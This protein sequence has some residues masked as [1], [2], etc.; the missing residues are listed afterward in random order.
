MR[1]MSYRSYGRPLEAVD[2]EIPKPGRGQ[3]LVKG[4]TSSVNPVDWKQA[5]GKI[6][7]IMPNKL[8]CVPGY[9][10]AG[11]VVTY[12]ADVTGFAPGDRVHARIAGINGG[13]CAEYALCGIDVLA[14]MPDGMD[15]ATAAGLPL[16]GMTA[17][18]GLRD[19]AK[20]PMHGATER[21]L[22]VGASGGV[23]H[24]ALQIARAAGATVFAVSSDRNA[25]LVRELGAS[26]VLDYNKPATF[27]DQPPFDVIFD[28]VAGDASK[29]CGLLTK[30]GRYA[31][32]VPGA[33]TFVRTAMSLFSSQRVAP[34]MLKS[35]AADLAFLDALFQAN[36]LRILIG[37]RFPLASLQDAWSRSE[38]GRATGKLIVDIAN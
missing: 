26:D 12:G 23:G 29:W 31:S 24:I 21:V 1:A 16:A 36:K 25:G 19:G 20:L 15:F 17:L 11:E 32:C 8:P 9:D 3:V 27:G 13:A 7:L 4:S 37:A 38:S 2:L 35:N 22:V 14:K 10:Y 18:Q 30:R 5:S 33:G 28:C 6:R 34:V